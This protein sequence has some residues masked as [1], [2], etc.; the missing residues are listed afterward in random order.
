MAENMRDELT[1][2]IEHLSTVDKTDAGYDR[3]LTYEEI[4]DALLASP[5]ITALQSQAW[6]LGFSAGQRYADQR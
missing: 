5:V 6:D 4:A 1:E 2:L 3:M